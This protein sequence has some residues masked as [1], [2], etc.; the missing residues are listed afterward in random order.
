MTELHDIRHSLAILRVRRG[1]IRWGTAYAAVGI[2]L[3]WALAVLFFIDVAFHLSVFQR[4][5]LFFVT[6]GCI[7]WSGRRFVLP[8]FGVRESESTLALLVERQHGID[9]DLVAALQFSRPEAVNWGSTQLEAAVMSRVAERAPQIDVFRGLRYDTLAVRLKILGAT[10]VAALVLAALYPAHIRVF[11]DRLL[12]SSRQYPSDTK[13]DQ[14]TINAQVAFRWDPVNRSPQTVACAEGQPVHFAVLATGTLPDD[15]LVTCY[16]PQ[17]SEARNLVLRRLRPGEFEQ[18]KLGTSRR[19]EGPTDSRPNTPSTWYLATLPQLLDEFQYSVRLGDTSTEMGRVRMIALPVAEVDIQVTPPDYVRGADAKLRSSRHVA[20][21]EGSRVT[22]S[23]QSVNKK[24]LRG[25][26]VRLQYAG[27]SSE[28]KLTRQDKSGRTWQL[29]A[30][31]SPLQ[32]VEHEIRYEIQVEDVDGLQLDVPLQGVIQL[33]PDRL[34]SAVAQTVHRVVLAGAHPVVAFRVSDDYG[35]QAIRL[36]TQVQR[37]DSDGGDSDAE[38]PPMTNEI[39]IPFEP[40]PL[41]GSSVRYRGQ[42]EL[43]LTPL[44]LS[45]GDQLKLTLETI[46]YRGSLPGRSYLTEPLLLEVSDEAGVLAAITEADEQSEKQ[47]NEAIQQQ[48]GVEPAP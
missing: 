35:I 2:T 39:D 38:R 20:V 3:L 10:V 42:Y 11:F 16:S 27:Q 12:L 26:S 5:A 17:T 30:Q 22:M 1:R 34:P 19:A 23:V 24:Q 15:G 44:Q 37:H 25:V 14:I 40:R 31:D 13:I 32:Q 8:F 7:A 29:D 43:D 21:V 47:L 48:L 33:T 4:V 28:W 41:I 18:V 46:D 6:A 45:K 36:Q 9:T